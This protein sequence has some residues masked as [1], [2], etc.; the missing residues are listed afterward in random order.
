MSQKL[1]SRPSVEV[2]AHDSNPLCWRMRIAGGATSQFHSHRGSADHC[3]APVEPSRQ[4]CKRGARAASP[5]HNSLPDT[6]LPLLLSGLNTRTAICRLKYSR[7]RT[8]HETTVLCSHRCCMPERL[9]NTG[10]SKRWR[11][12]T[13]LNGNPGFDS[14]PA[15]SQRAP[16][17]HIWGGHH[18]LV[19]NAADIGAGR[20]GSCCCL[21][22][23]IRN[24]RAYLHALLQHQ[25]RTGRPSGIRSLNVRGHVYLHNDYLQRR[26]HVVR[27]QLANGRLLVWAGGAEQP[28]RCSTILDS[29][30]AVDG[31]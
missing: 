23:H 26:P 31:A 20:Q 9:S 16:H 6:T 17:Q 22:K 11:P 8:H 15:L 13:L 4:H 24:E 1:P 12:H 29:P 14:A 10:T 3:S 7:T 30:L 21:L 28:S 25:L 5:G 27:V 19:A 18:P 2:S